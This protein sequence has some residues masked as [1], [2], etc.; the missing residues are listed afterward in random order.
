MDRKGIISIYEN[1]PSLRKEVLNR[2]LLGYSTREIADELFNSKTDPVACVA[3]HLKEIYKNY[4]IFLEKADPESKRSH[5]IILFHSEAPNLIARLKIKLGDPL[6][7]GKRSKQFGDISGEYKFE[8]KKVFKEEI[9]ILQ[10][11]GRKYFDA[12]DHLPTK[13]L[14][15]W[16]DKDSNSFRKI[17]NK[18][19][20]PVGFFIILFPK[21]R[22]IEE[23]SR[24]D[25]IERELKSSL[26]LSGYQLKPGQL[27]RSAF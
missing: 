8:L 26:L 7:F 22:T 2:I 20:R 25:L 13:L 24:G 16:H 4:R 17:Q 1:L 23:F 5:L 11:Q 14:E 21:S 15:S 12:Q 3:A 9:P 10:A 18:N 19:G 6:R 27:V